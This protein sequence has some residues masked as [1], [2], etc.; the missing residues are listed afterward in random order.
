VLS[1][2]ATFTGYIKL[3]DTA[4]WLALTDR[5][6]AHG[7]SLAGL[8]PSSY[9]ATLDVTLAKGYPFGA[10]LPLG[11]GRALT[12]ESSVWV[13]QPYLAFLGGTLALCLYA[14]ATPLVTSRRLRALVAFVAAQPA[15]L[16]GYALWGGMKE[17]A[18]AA[19]LALVAALLAP[20]LRS[21]PTV[22]S[23]LCAAVASAAVL[24]ALSVGGVVW[25]GP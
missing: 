1:G 18:G 7:H 13:F 5:V 19:L 17:I 23:V 25:L 21:P 2:A 10:F 24:D 14:L 9:R 16:F 4:T 12:G 15:L 20:I 6:M 11:V 22:G 3:D 8:P